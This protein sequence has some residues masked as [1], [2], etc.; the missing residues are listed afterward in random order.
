MATGPSGR[1]DQ[2]HAEAFAGRGCI[3]WLPSRAPSFA[4]RTRAACRGGK[5][6]N[7]LMFLVFFNTSLLKKT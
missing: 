2:L 6:F 1:G 5:C 3:A 7:S 4:A